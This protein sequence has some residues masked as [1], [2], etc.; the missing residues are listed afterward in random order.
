[1]SLSLSLFLFS[2]RSSASN[3]ILKSE[4]E[5]YQWLENELLQTVKSEFHQKMK[6]QSNKV[7]YLFRFLFSLSNIKKHK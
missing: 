6:K 4:L 3:D 1:M 7:E 5:R 2:R